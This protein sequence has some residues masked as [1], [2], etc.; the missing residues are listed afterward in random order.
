[1]TLA[2]VIAENGGGEAP[3]VRDR[4][5]RRWGEVGDREVADHFRRDV[6]WQDH[7]LARAHGPEITSTAAPAPSG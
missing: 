5:A 2:V 7:A 4:A 1:L 6:K 3:A